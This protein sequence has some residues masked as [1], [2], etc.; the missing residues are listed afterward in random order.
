MNSPKQTE[1]LE[2]YRRA[3]EKIHRAKNEM[4]EALRIAEN[5]GLRWTSRI[6]KK[7]GELEALET[8]FKNLAQQ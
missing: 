7:T 5:N 4:L 8:V 1:R 3:T 2:A 6:S